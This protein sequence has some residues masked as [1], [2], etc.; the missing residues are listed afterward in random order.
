MVT[1]EQVKENYR[2]VLEIK[3]LLRKM[4]QK[5]ES[6]MHTYLVGTI[7]K[8]LPQ[9]DINAI[10]EDYKV[11]KQQAQDKFKELL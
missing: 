9:A 1:Q 4:E 10:I 6:A 5:H 3:L 7:Q 2:K 8:T 11:L